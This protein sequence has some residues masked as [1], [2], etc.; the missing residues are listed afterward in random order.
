MVPKYITYF[1]LQQV[2]RYAYSWYH[3]LPIVALSPAYAP[4]RLDASTSS[5][6]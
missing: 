3:N 1:S 6:Y 5:R 2:G 4:G